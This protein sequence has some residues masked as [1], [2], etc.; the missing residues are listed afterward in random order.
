MKKTMIKMAVTGAMA[1]LMAT[2]AWAGNMGTSQPYGQG[3]GMTAYVMTLPAG[4]LSEAEMATLLHMREEEKLARDVY[5]TLYHTWNH[6]AFERISNSEQRHMDAVLA[7]MEKYDVADPVTD[8]ATGTFADADMA[9]LYEQM[10]ETGTQSLA[11]ALRMGATIEDLDIADLLDAI[12]EADDEDLVAVYQ[13][14]LKGSRNHLRSFVYQLGV[15]GE[16]YTPQYIST[17]TFTAIVTSA[18]ERGLVD[19]D[20]NPVVTGNG[21]GRRGR[22]KGT[23][24]CPTTI[25]DDTEADTSTNLSAILPIDHTPLLAR[26]GKGGGGRGPGDGTGNGGKGPKDGSGNGRKRGTCINTDAA[27]AGT[28]MLLARGGNGGGGRGPGDGTGNGGKGPKDG[29]GNGR[30]SGTC[31][32][33]DAVSAG[34]DMILARG[35]N[36]GGGHGSGNGSGNGGDGPGDGTGNGSTAGDCSSV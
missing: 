29:S 31:I 8:D 23:G 34:A 30:K 26:G 2:T 33:T 25:T 24:D 5:T 21:Q 1:G 28:D 3:S 27:S 17:E 13:N 14:L 4:E 18:R 36:G 7:L 11:D 12:D 15:L 35:G 6:W 32:N 19:A 16:T 9:D 10:V 22:G 20:G